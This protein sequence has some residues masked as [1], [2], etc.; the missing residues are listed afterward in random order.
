MQLE[1]IRFDERTF[2]SKCFRVLDFFISFRKIF[3]PFGWLSYKKETVTVMLAYG[4]GLDAGDLLTFFKLLYSLIGQG[5][6]EN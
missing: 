1:D 2:A 5:T 6:Q 3:L 4:Q